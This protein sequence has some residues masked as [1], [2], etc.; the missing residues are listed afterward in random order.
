MKVAPRRENRQKTEIRPKSFR[1]LLTG[2][3]NCGKSTLFNDLTGL[4]QKTGNYQGV[5][6]EKAEGKIIHGDESISLIDLPGAYSLGGESEDK[7]VTTR[8]LLFRESSDRVLFLLDGVAVERGLQFLLQICA[9]KIPMLVAVSMKD[10]L[11]K[12]G[13]RLELSKLSEEFGCDFVFVNPRTGEGVDELR[14][15]LFQES[16]YRIPNPTFQWDSKRQNFLDN[17]VS[18]F[19]S[20]DLDSFRFVLENSLKELSGEKLQN[21]LPG[22]SILPERAKSVLVSEFESSGLRFS[23]REELIQRS[24]WI[25]KLLSKSLIGSEVKSGSLLSKADRVLLHP[26]WGLLSFLGIMALVFQS[27]FSWSEFPMNWIDT[28]IGHLADTVGTLLPNGPVKALIQEGVIGGVGAVLVFIPQIS[29]LFF[30]IGIMEESG[31]IARASFVMDRFMGR[32]GLSGKSFIPLLSSAAC[33]VPAIMGTRTIENKA[34]RITTILVSPLITCSARYPVYILVIGTVFP[35]TPIFGFFQ[36]KALV[37]FGLFV[38][39]MIASMLAAL[40]FKKTFFQSEPSYFLMELPRYQIPSIKGLVLTVYRK[41]KAFVANAGKIILF[42]SI[43]LWF[44]AN[45]PRVEE[46]KL[47]MHSLAEAKSIQISESYAGRFGKTMEPILKPIGFG[48]KMGIGLLTSFAAREIMVSTLSIVY[49]V[50]GDDSEDQ[51]LRSA[52]KKDMDPITGKPVW[53]FASGVSLLI[54]FAFACQCMST[55]AVVRKETNSLFWPFFLFAYMTILAYGSSLLVYQ[56][57]RLF[58]MA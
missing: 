12:K 8:M 48:W 31:Y 30:F 16:S 24:I 34:D 49:G 10:T 29:L 51:N 21:G 7:Q 17:L 2:N 23:Y 27:L 1:L 9:L 46:S 42:I 13:L 28:E 37:L 22:L 32:F 35:S 52:L 38:L 19:T 33:A 40:V 43:L 44:L 11:E 4:R 15:T 36:T 6:V 41:I 54:F 25:K 20:D 58:G 53:N 5:T 26:F 55:L 3:P 18:K 45:Y 50:Q 47:Q 39:G 57:F 56:T 14:E